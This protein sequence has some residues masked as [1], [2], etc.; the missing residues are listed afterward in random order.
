MAYMRADMPAWRALLFA[1]IL[2]K[3][4]V[5]ARIRVALTAS[6]WTLRTACPRLRRNAGSC[7]RLPGRFAKAAPMCWCA[8]TARGIRPSAISRQRRAPTSWRSVSQGR[9]P[10]HLGVVAELL[11]GLEAA[12]VLPAGH[13]RLV[14]LVETAD[15]HFRAREIA[16]ATPPLVAMSLGAEDFALSVGM[17]LSPRRCRRRS[18]RRSSPPA[19]PIMGTVA[20]FKDTEAFRDVVRRSRKFGFAAASCIHPSVVRVL[21]EEYGVAPEAADRRGA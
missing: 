12:R 4:F 15:A 18:R 16:K 19:P 11:D 6:S 13:T 10:E 20:D 17:G 5:A 7:L 3:K 9:E 2:R 1:P 21:N 8:S 14:A